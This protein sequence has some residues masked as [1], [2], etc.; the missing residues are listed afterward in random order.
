MEKLFHQCIKGK[1]TITFVHNSSLL[2]ANEALGLPIV[3]SSLV[4]VPGLAKPVDSRSGWDRK[5]RSLTKD[6][7]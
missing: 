3:W 2:S 6:D 7:G 5:L 1:T 4:P